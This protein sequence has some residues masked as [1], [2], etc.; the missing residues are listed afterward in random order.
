MHVKQ[1]PKGQ[2]PRVPGKPPEGPRPRME[3]EN[4]FSLRNIGDPPRY[5][6]EKPRLEGLPPI[7]VGTGSVSP[8]QPRDEAL[9]TLGTF[10]I[11]IGTVLA[12]AG[13]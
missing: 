12:I 7:K 1:P 9:Y 10:C 11:L 6:W 3:G 8:D 4:P 5:E 2:R 13:F